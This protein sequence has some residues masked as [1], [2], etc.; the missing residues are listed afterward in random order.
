MNE[1]TILICDTEESLNFCFVGIS[2]VSPLIFTS[3]SPTL[4]DSEVVDIAVSVIVVEG[5]S[6]CCVKY[7]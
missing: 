3:F 5:A 2:V 4:T 1:S 6:F 7:R